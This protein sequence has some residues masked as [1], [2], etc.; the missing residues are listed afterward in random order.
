MKFEGYAY[1]FKLNASH[2]LEIGGKRSN[3]HQH[4][5]EISLFIK[6]ISE[7]FVMYDDVEKIVEKYLT[8]YSEKELNKIEPFNKI[9]PTLENIGDVLYKRLKEVLYKKDIKL[10]KLEISENPARVYIAGED[11]EESQKYKKEIVELTM[12]SIV[13]LSTKQLTGKYEHFDADD[14]K[15]QN[16]KY[17]AKSESQPVKSSIKV[18]KDKIEKVQECSE[19]HLFIKTLC[20]VSVLAAGA[21]MLVIYLLS[22]KKYPWGL[23]TYGHIFKANLLYKDIKAGNIYPLFT[24]FWYNG[25]QPFRYWGPFSYYVLAACQFLAGGNP[26]NGYVFFIGIVFFIGGFGWLIWGI[27]EKKILLSTILAVLWFFLPENIRILLFEGNL[28]R[29]VITMFVPYLFYFMWQFVNYKKNWAIIPMNI[30]MIFVIMTHLMTAAMLGITSFIFMAVYSLSLKNVKRPFQVIVSMLLSFA[31]CG[32]WVYPSLKGGLVSMDSGATSSVMKSLSTPFTVSLNPFIRLSSTGRSGYF[33]FGLSILIISVLGIFLSNKKSL[34]GFVTA[35]IV[36]LG[37][38]T[39]FVPL[40]SKMPLSQLLWMIRFT[41]IVY[42][43]F[44]IS[45]LNWKSCKKLFMAAMLILIILDS[46]LSFNFSLYPTESSA[47]DKEILS[48]T[49]EITKQRIALL[50]D[51]LFESYPSF[52]FTSTGKEVPYSYGWAWQGA[53]TANNI[54]LLNTALENGYYNYMFDRSLELGCDTVLV[55]KSVLRKDKMSLSDIESGAKLSGY[56]LYKETDMGYVFHK[57]TPQNFGVVT[58]YSMLG[59]GHSADEIPLQYPSCKTGSSQNLEDYSIDELKKYKTIYLSD[60]KYNDR[61]KAEEMVSKLSSMGV[62]VVIDMNKILPDPV[63]KRMTFLGVTAQPVTFYNKLPD[64]FL[65][66]VK[67]E[68]ADFKEEYKNW[69]TVYLDNVPDVCGFSWMNEKKLAFMGKGKGENSNVT[70]MGFNLMFHAM[71]NNDSGVIN[72]MNNIFKSDSSKLPKRTVVP[73]SV[74]YGRNSITITSPK[75]DVNTTIAY[76]D[77]YKSSSK[78]YPSENFLNVEKGQ[79][80]VNVTYPYLYQGIVV[81]IIGVLG[82]SVLLFFIHRNG[83]D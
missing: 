50:D 80:V 38:T 75:D 16:M 65:N 9:E 78:I 55:K 31:V 67:Y 83:V 3:V 62:N 41:P 49:K 25:V 76:L 54:V 60:F 52:Y 59:I 66:N 28:P 81:S 27:K 22:L 13:D 42:G 10:L 30:F 57:D 74:E 46:S 72:M 24:E 51:S 56:Y 39:A 35:V 47:E 12:N 73:V 6:M 2:S 20:S 36:F 64:M 32:V 37:T 21:V 7:K 33:Y 17:P 14:V 43:L 45:I 15:K 11:D 53:A 23:D 26:I 40:L 8:R 77:A 19:K 79:T 5:F 18:K 61:K 82:M 44:V 29:V 71:T 68:S 69:N 4:T 34:P 63:T 1:K 70:F 48:L 58:E